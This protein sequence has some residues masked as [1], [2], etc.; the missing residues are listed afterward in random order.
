M[1]SIGLACAVATLLFPATAQAICAFP[2]VSTAEYGRRMF[3]RSDLVADVRVG[4]ISRP[5]PGFCDAKP[6]LAQPASVAQFHTATVLRAFKGS[7][8]ETIRIN[9]RPLDRING[10]CT[11]VVVSEETQLVSGTVQRL[12]LR[13]VG[14]HTF[15][16]IDGCGQSWLDE[17]LANRF[18]PI[19]AYPQ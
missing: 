3:A 6:P 1:R 15:E 14:R 4:P 19:P 8:S 5:P 2:T 7:A 16:P 11:T 18:G 9:V 12:G 13:R 17:L 10:V